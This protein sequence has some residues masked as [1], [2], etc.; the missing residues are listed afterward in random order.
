MD[1][2][3]INKTISNL[4]KPVKV[5][6]EKS[7]SVYDFFMKKLH[8]TKSYKFDQFKPIKRDGPGYQVNSTFETVHSTL[9]ALIKMSTSDL[10]CIPYEDSTIPLEY[11]AIKKQNRIKCKDM[12]TTIKQFPE[13]LSFG[14]KFGDFKV[15]HVVAKY[16]LWAKNTDKRCSAAGLPLNEGLLKKAADRMGVIKRVLKVDN[17]VAIALLGSFYCEMGWGFGSKAAMY[18]S[19]E[20]KAT[21]ET[22]AENP[23]STGAQTPAPKPAAPKPTTPAT[24]APASTETK[25]VNE[26]VPDFA[27][28]PANCGECW[29]GV[30][31]FDQKKIVIKALKNDPEV[32]SQCAGI[33]EDPDKYAASSQQ[34]SDLQ[35]DLIQTKIVY[36]YFTKIQKEAY[37]LIKGADGVKRLIACYL[38]KAGTAH[39]SKA[40][41]RKYGVYSMENMKA[42]VNAY[43]KTHEKQNKTDDNPDYKAVNTFAKQV[44]A[45]CIL[46]EYL[47][48]KKVPKIED[49]DKKLKK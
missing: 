22:P 1:I 15:P 2:Y 43:I 3:A 24:P 26:A 16:C 38:Y 39:G 23:Q 21:I 46:G 28:G 44:Y 7:K 30:T 40:L 32:G 8:K 31:N 48:T 19:T 6:R 4:F 27:A 9:D 37:K 18:N 33:P 17:N 14:I 47:K 29:C 36:Y 13:L 34:L 25:K 5:I 11:Y 20:S 35:D 41:R 45:S 49:I 10:L 12:E 42:A